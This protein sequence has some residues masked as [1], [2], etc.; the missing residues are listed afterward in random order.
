[1]RE[2]KRER[3]SEREGRRLSALRLLAQTPPPVTVTV[4]LSPSLHLYLMRW[5]ERKRFALAKNITLAVGQLDTGLLA[6]W[7]RGKLEELYTGG[8]GVVGPEPGVWRP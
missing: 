8:V 2:R 7:R 6:G 1:M 3:A 4:S 5:L